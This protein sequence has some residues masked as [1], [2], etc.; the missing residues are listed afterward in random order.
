NR[1]NGGLGAARN[2]GIREARGVYLMFAD[3]DDKVARTAIDRMLKT[4]EHTGSDF[5]VGSA[6]R[7]RGNRTW[8]AKWVK[9][10]HRH[11]RLGITLHEYPEIM[12]NVFAWAK[13]WRTEF[14]KRTVGGF[15]E[16]IR[17]EDLEPTLISYLYA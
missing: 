6:S 17:H 15:P 7:F 1:P 9:Q 4:L 8:M 5:V 12:S 14:F 16:G 10:V 11:E 3:S 13:L 2:T